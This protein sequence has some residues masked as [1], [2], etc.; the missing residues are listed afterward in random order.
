MKYF[1]ISIMLLILCGTTAAR[2]S[3]KEL[4]NYCTAMFPKDDSRIEAVYTDLVESIREVYLFHAKEK[5]E[6]QT[7]L[8][9]VKRQR[10]PASLAS[11]GMPEPIIQLLSSYVGLKN[12][13]DDGVAKAFPIQSGNVRGNSQQDELLFRTLQFARNQLSLNR[14]YFLDWDGSWVPKVL[15]KNFNGEPAKDSAPAFFDELKAAAPVIENLEKFKQFRD[16][17]H[18]Q[19]LAPHH[20]SVEFEPIGATEVRRAKIL[21]TTS[22]PLMRFAHRDSCFQIGSKYSHLLSIHFTVDREEKLGLNR[23]YTIILGRKG[24]RPTVRDEDF[25]DSDRHQELSMPQERGRPES[26]F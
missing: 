18:A 16:R 8:N 11:V 26:G 14:M 13:I 3:N 1:N 15:K 6:L 20:P 21:R 9:K 17:C 19:C 23:A 25:S 4:N 5:P 2:V 10:A 22:E 12:K 7:I 24:E